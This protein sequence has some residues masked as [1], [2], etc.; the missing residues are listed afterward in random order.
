MKIIPRI[1][2]T[3]LFFL[4][5]GTAVALDKSEPLL[6]A[7]IQ[8]NECV[9]GAG[10]REVLP[11]DVSIPTFFWINMKKK[12]IRVG[13]DSEPTAIERIEDIEGRTI[14]QGAD[15]GSEDL[16]DGSGWTMS[17]EDETGRMTGTA[18]TRQ[19]AIVI[20]GTCTEY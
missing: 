2:L 16:A 19:A 3:L 15:P 18:I 6:C 12:E 9:D 5:A 14:M 17:I 1:G 7:S 8:V 4:A 13:K 11:E 10:C 20:F